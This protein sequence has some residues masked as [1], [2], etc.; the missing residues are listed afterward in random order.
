MNG[1][2]RT[3]RFVGNYGYYGGLRR[4]PRGSRS[5]RR[6]SDLYGG[7]SIFSSLLSLIVASLRTTCFSWLL[8]LLLLV[9]SLFPRSEAEMEWVD[10]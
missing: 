3:L 4:E 5:R 10:L 8:V 7:D 2:D 6:K 1:F 9:L